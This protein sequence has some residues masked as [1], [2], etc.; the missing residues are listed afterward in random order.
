MDCVPTENAF[1]W[2]HSLFGLCVQGYGQVFSFLFGYLSIFCWLCAMLPQILE[3]YTQKSAEGLS[4]YLLYFWLAGDIANVTSCFLNHQLPFQIYLSA[5]YC[6]TDFVLLF[7]YFYYRKPRVCPEMK[8]C[9]T[10]ASFSTYGSTTQGHVQLFGLFIFGV[11]VT[12][13]VSSEPILNT[14]L[15][16]PALAWI[17]TTFYLCS[18]IPQ[19]LKNHQRHSVEGLSLGLFSFAVGGN[20][21]Y[22]LSILLRPNH[23]RETFLCALPY[24]VSSF[25][26]LLMDL[27][28]FIQFIHYPKPKDNYHEVSSLLY[29]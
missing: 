27:V 6:I 17:C 13:S 26:T 20:V 3:N 8:Q 4:L 7:Q 23:T 10:V 16:G 28:I 15:V 19:I 12:Q 2:I 5:Y 14:T 25:G 9:E 11:Q 29:P 18:R 21:T 22:A 1:Q 24:I